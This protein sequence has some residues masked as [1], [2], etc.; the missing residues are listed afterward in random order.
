MTA[1]SVVNKLYWLS[2]DAHGVQ[3]ENEALAFIIR[4]SR[5]SQKL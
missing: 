1:V 3:T 5:K 2:A 4:N